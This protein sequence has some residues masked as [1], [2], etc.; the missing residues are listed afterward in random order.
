MDINRRTFALFGATALGGAA[1][2]G[3]AFA[4]APAA[5]RGVLVQEAGASVRVAVALSEAAAARTMFLAGPDRF[6]IDVQ[7]A[8]LAMPSSAP[9]AGVVRAVRCAQHASHARLVL[10]L[11]APARLI[12]QDFG[13]RRAPQ[14]QFELAATAPF[15]AAPPPAPQR[16]R[17]RKTVV[18]DAGHGGRDP[19]AIGRTLGVY[20]KNVVLDAALKL[21]DALNQRGNYRVVLT[22][23]A[24][25]YVEHAERVR[26]SREANAELF[27]SLHADANANTEAHGASVYTLDERGARRAQNMMGD[28]IDLGDDPVPAAA[29][30]VLV[31]LFQRETTNRSAQFA[32]IVIPRIGE[33]APLLRNTHRSANLYVLLAPDV[34]AVLVETGFLTNAVDERRL[35]QP[36]EREAMAE[37][38]AR[39]VDA[40]FAAPQLMAS[41]A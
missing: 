31:D 16:A 23:D 1:L 38:I 6:V 8:V 4:N 2:S 7:N 36:R 9:G 19:G 40:Y 32:E 30:G 25:R 41:G 11:A 14:M 5:V 22:R 18:I 37:A 35:N 17:A 28:T 26:I 15:A 27:I 24:D 13:G 21:R 34:P 33:V 3:R 20:E 10:D 39:S 12:D 29:R